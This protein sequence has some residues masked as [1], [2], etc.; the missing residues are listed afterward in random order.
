MKNAADSRA[1]TYS[2]NTCKV[3][4]LEFGMKLL[5]DL[6]LGSLVYKT[7]KR[8]KIITCRRRDVQWKE[9]AKWPGV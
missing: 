4:T 9:D 3:G 6:Q 1:T 5:F 7:S 8:K 2:D